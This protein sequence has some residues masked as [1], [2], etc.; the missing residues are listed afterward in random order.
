MAIR[1][2][3][4]TLR[5]A[6]GD[7]DSASASFAARPLEFGR[8]VLDELVGRR[9]QPIAWSLQQVSV[10][11]AATRRADVASGDSVWADTQ[12]WCHE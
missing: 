6:A 4:H 10:L 1:L 12:P 7:I 9:C 8:W 3:A 2:F 11:R 5:T